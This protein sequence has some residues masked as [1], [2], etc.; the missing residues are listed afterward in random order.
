MRGR[1][2]WKETWEDDDERN[3]DLDEKFE[4]Q[5]ALYGPAVTR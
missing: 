4:K 2:S 3:V 5:K 1:H